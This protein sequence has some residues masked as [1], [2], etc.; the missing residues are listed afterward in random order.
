[1]K[2][3]AVFWQEGESIKD[4]QPIVVMQ[5]GNQESFDF[6][7]KD[8]EANA[9]TNEIFIELAE[10]I[11]MNSFQERGYNLFNVG[12]GLV[13]ECLYPVSGIANP[14]LNNKFPHNVKGISAIDRKNIPTDPGERGGVFQGGLMEEPWVFFSQGTNFGIFR[15]RCVS[16]HTIRDFLPFGT[17]DRIGQFHSGDTLSYPSPEGPLLGVQ[18]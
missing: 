10:D 17:S 18:S 15:D 13:R 9:V 16:N 1:M 12:K 14:F 8:A 2:S 5:G 11:E 7:M 3:I 6:L 4:D